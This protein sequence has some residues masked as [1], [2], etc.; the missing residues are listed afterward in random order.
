MNPTRSPA[1]HAAIRVAALLAGVA[2]T[3]AWAQPDV[4]DASPAERLVFMLPHLANIQPP[5]TLR[6]AYVEEGGAGGPLTDA[7]AIEL[8]ADAAGACCS[9]RGSF[10]S[11]SRALG[12]PEIAQARSNP[13]LLY[14]LEHEV[15]QLQRQTGG[16]SAHFRRRMRLA[17]AQSATIS[18][19]TIRWRGR[20]AAAQVVHIAP[21]VD[22]P[23][24]DR[25]AETSKKEYDFVMSEAVPGGVYQVLTRVPGTQ[26]RETLTLQENS[27]G[28][29]PA[30]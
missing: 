26:R 6:Y 30:R 24:R 23:F 15:R 18:P 29:S 1:A 13:A 4:L 5:R 7:M 17:L 11:G 28:R 8:R 10:L 14:F 22:D 27:D 2:S 21:F 19:T 9:A 20:D 16:Q 3:C 25:F 12:L